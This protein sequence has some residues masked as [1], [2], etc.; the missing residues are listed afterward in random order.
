MG[1][2]KLELS[3]SKEVAIFYHK[4]DAGDYKF[5]LFHNRRGKLTSVLPHLDKFCVKFITL[6]PEMLYDFRHPSFRVSQ[7]PS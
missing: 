6:L 5:L 4:A 7:V 1:D 3:N 2:C